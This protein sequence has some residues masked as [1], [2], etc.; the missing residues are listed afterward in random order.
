MLSRLEIILQY[1]DN[2]RAK[3]GG[4][5]LGLNTSL[6]APSVVGQALLARLELRALQLS[7]PPTTDP[8]L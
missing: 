4:A 1:K 3:Y 5:H 6:E 2:S 7:E 8:L